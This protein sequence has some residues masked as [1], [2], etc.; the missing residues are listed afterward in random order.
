MLYPF[1]EFHILIL[2][3]YDSNELFKFQYL[4][5]FNSCDVS[6]VL[7]DQHFFRIVYLKQEVF[8][9][10]AFHKSVSLAEGCQLAKKKL[11]AWFILGYLIY[12]NMTFSISVLQEQT[13]FQHGP[14]FVVFNSMSIILAPLSKYM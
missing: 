8:F 6:L 5:F 4:S 13:H 7:L 3:R 14:H 10:P 9:D 1:S 2:T 11:I 12:K